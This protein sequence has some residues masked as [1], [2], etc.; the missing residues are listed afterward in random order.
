AP[1]APAA[2]QVPEPPSAP[3]GSE[4]DPFGEDGD[5]R[6]PIASAP[7]AF[8]PDDFGLEDDGAAPAVPAASGPA[9]SAPGPAEAAPPSP[10]PAPSV[11]DEEATVTPTQRPA[12]D[13]ATDPAPAPS[14]AFD[15]PDP[16]VSSPPPQAAG[17]AA[18]ATAPEE[19]PAPAAPQT[20]PPATVVSAT[21]GE[22]AGARALLRALGAE[23]VRIDDADIVPTMSR[24]G[25]VLRIVIEGIREV[26]M[27]RTSIK[28][29]FRI[30]QTMIASG[31]NNPLKF[32]ISPEQ[33]V[34]AIVRPKAKGY[35]DSTDAATE[36]LRD[37]KAHEVAMVSGMEAALKGVLKRLD[38]A[39]LEG[40]IQ[41]GGGLGG[42]LKSKKARY[43]EVYEQMYAE[44][45]DQAEN[46]FHELFAKEFARA[47]Q[48]QLDKLK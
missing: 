18:E 2:R 28:S 32:S 43:W 21:P 30:Q 6:P 47:Y 8:I 25:H 14:D 12:P 45:S 3:P 31:G 1:P 41:A 15:D 22:E 29:E 34:E 26:L 24:L 27:T 7:S 46:E 16:T 10:A 5:S 20:P 17:D 11:P 40:K 9:Q 48:D 33:A 44:I 19:A 37:I 42:M 36:A 4:G 38:P 35:L 23:D 13:P 39:E